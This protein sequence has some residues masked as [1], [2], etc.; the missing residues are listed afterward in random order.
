[1]DVDSA[2][3][4]TRY[5]AEYYSDDAYSG[6]YDALPFTLDDTLFVPSSSPVPNIDAELNE[7]FFTY[8]VSEMVPTS[9]TEALHAINNDSFVIQDVNV[10]DCVVGRGEEDKG[11]DKVKTEET[12]MENQWVKY[13]PIECRLKITLP[14]ELVFTRKRKS[15]RIR[16]KKLCP[17][18]VKK[19]RK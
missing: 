4:Y 16:V 10:T 6:C 5:T 8:P 2:V 15:E 17:E 1:M 11:G 19:S 7:R 3:G 9:S 18:V 13:D 12:I 14:S